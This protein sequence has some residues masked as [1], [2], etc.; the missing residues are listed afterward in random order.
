MLMK[1]YAAQPNST[2]I[3]CVS[4]RPM[5]EEE[6]AILGFGYTDDTCWRNKLMFGFVPSRVLMKNYLYF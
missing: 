5:A 4:Q 6:K 2:V 1:K 3:I